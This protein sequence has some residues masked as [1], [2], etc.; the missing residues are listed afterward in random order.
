MKAAGLSPISARV[1]E[2]LTRVANFWQNC[3]SG[4]GFGPDAKAGSDSHRSGRSPL[5]FRVNSLSEE[6]FFLTINLSQS[7]ILS[8]ESS[9]SEHLSFSCS[10]AKTGRLARMA[11]DKVKTRTVFIIMVFL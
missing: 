1:P 8:A 7:A 5:F 9:L 11:A 6:V 3:S 4:W 10:T 2:V